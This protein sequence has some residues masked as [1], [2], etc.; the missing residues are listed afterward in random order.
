[1]CC[2]LG[3]ELIP[4][5]DLRLAE[6]GRYFF[7]GIPQRART[8]HAL[9]IR[10]VRYFWRSSYGA[11]LTTPT[12]ICLQGLACHPG[13]GVVTH[14]AKAQQG[15]A[16]LRQNLQRKSS[17]FDCLLTGLLAI[18][19]PKKRN[20]PRRRARRLRRRP[21]F[22]RKR[23]AFPAGLNQRM[24]RRRSRRH[25]DSICHSWTTTLPQVPCVPSM[26]R[27]STML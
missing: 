3:Q 9:F 8:M 11:H 2:P 22:E 19:K 5:P 13:R 25:A 21:C 24:P 12:S 17:E 18:G 15:A 26:L 20:E 10:G 7:A 14:L 27:V 6:A 16:A 4:H 1:M 23:P